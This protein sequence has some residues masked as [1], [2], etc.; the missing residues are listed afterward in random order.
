MYKW[1]EATKQ[2]R[3]NELQAT[4]RFLAN[5]KNKYLTIFESLHDPV[6]LLDN[7]SNVTNMNHAAAKLLIGP[8]AR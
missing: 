4:N 8:L 2:G 3:L 6:I 5:E 1:A 7:N